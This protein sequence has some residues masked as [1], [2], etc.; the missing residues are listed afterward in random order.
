V[1]TVKKP[2]IPLNIVKKEFEKIID[3]RKMLLYQALVII[4]MVDYP[5][6]PLEPALLPSMAHLEII[7]NLH[8]VDNTANTMDLI[9]TSPIDNQ[10]LL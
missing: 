7:I 8:L 4:V 10:L 2:D 3:Y 1:G 5:R 6:I 9:M